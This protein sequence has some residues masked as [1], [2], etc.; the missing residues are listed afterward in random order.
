M[1][2]LRAN[3][4]IEHRVWLRTIFLGCGSKKR[5]LQPDPRA[6][7]SGW[8]LSD[9][10]GKGHSWY[11]PPSPRRGKTRQ[12][13]TKA[14]E[15]SSAPEKYRLR[16]DQREKVKREEIKWG[17]FCDRNCKRRAEK[18]FGD[19]GT[20]NPSVKSSLPPYAASAAVAK[21]KREEGTPAVQDSPAH[22]NAFMNELHMTVIPLL[23]VSRTPSM[24][25]NGSDKWEWE[26]QW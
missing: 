2:D 10:R 18:H 16:P 6:N 24:P 5:S 23:S 4:T 1:K 14:V 12:A 17:Q 11:P 26:P 13:I 25:S 3:I 8:C 21:R 7:D 22:P 9:N 19:H 15:E 20:K